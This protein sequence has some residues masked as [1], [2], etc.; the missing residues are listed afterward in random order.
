MKQLP[1]DIAPPREPSFENFVPGS[2]AEVLAQLRAQPTELRHG[3]AAPLY[4]WGPAGSGKTHLLRALEARARAGG[5]AVGWF[6]ADQPLPWELAP[7]WSLVLIDRCE[8]LSPAAQHAAFALFVEAATL[9]VRVVAAGRLPPVDLP[10]RD[11]LRTRLGWGPVYGLKALDEAEVRAALQR[12]TGRRG[13]QLPDEL[14]D[15]LLTRFPRDLGSLMA[16]LQ[17]LDTYAMVHKRRLTVPL[18]REML[19]EERPQAALP[20]AAQGVP[21]A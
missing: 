6:D 20:P 8:S 21:A 1:L 12:D 14:T 2:N 11:D 10:V 15:H 5:L 13:L 4:L 18:L 7:G 9:G 3:A 16:L 19:A 17:R